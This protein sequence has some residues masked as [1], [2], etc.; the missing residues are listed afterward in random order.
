MNSSSTNTQNYQ[1]AQ[2][3][4]KIGNILRARCPSC[5][6]GAVNKGLFGIYP[7]CRNCN[8]DFN[9]EPGFYLGAIAISFIVTALATVPPMI[10]LKVMNVDMAI[11]F[12]FPLV[13]FIF[14]GSFLMF[15]SKI[16]WL[17]LEY[18]MT[19]QLDH[20]K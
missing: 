9:P 10:V 6:V 15:Y 12:A 18:R 8:Y 7:R 4:M 13:E 11:L 16:L 2:H 17:H 14:V 1:H 19:K 3:A 20:R 5:G